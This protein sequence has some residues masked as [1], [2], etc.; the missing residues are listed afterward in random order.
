MR[1]R[2]RSRK[3]LPCK[4]SQEIKLKALGPEVFTE[5]VEFRQWASALGR[6]TRRTPKESRD[7]SKNTWASSKRG[8]R[9]SPQQEEA[10]SPTLHVPVTPM[11][12]SP[13]SGR[14]HES[15]PQ[16]S[17]KV[18]RVVENVTQALSDNF[19]GALEWLSDK[20]VEVCSQQQATEVHAEAVQS[21]GYGSTKNTIS[22][23]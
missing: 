7:I 2:S 17:Q 10:P 15:S 8:S 20:F 3:V 6:L 14:R 12:R 4:L 22:D 13:P 1:P 16:S 18:V 11:A 23:D 5:E 9:P 21:I 19:K